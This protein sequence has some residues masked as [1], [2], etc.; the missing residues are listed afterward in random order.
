M[1]HKVL[2][3]IA[4]CVLAGVL[5]AAATAAIAQTQHRMLVGYPPGGAQDALARI[6]ADRLGTAVG[7]SFVVENRTGAA[8]VIAAEA[9]KNSA[10][11]GATLLMTADSNM[12]VYPHTTKRPAYNPLSDFIAIAHT[13]GYSVALAVGSDVPASD[14]KSFIALTRSRGAPTSYGTAGAGTNLHFYGLLLARSTDANLTHVPYRGSGPTIVDLIA[15]HVTAAVLPL[16]TFAQH[17]RAGKLRVLAHSGGTRSAS[18][19]D[20]PTFKELGFPALEVAGWFGVF[21]PAGTKPDIVAKYNEVIINHLRTPEV[22]QRM[23]GFELDTRELTPQEFQAMVKA[24]YERW[25]P[26]IRNSGFTGSSD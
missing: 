19:P 25:A 16:G 2:H 11:D 13:G 24:D 3:R 5:S 1:S 20:V 26:I 10:P 12:S 8:G 14:L 21:A 4:C 9:V 18:L 17:A 7:R 15:G 6:L 22:R 23:L